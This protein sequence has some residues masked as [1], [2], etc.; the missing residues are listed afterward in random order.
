MG[1]GAERELETFDYL[2]F[3][4]GIRWLAQRLADE[5]WIPD[6]I[7][8]VVRGGLFVAAGIAYASTSRTC[9]T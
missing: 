6:A 3:G 2:D 1:P 9:A 8:G 7:L 4:Q 5:R